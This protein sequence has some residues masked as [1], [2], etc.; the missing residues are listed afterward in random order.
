M[1]NT[2]IFY[3][4]HTA[5]TLRKYLM[6]CLLRLIHKFVFSIPGKI[7]IAQKNKYLGV[8]WKKSLILSWSFEVCCVYLFKLPH[9]GDFND[10]T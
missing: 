3:P 2:K 7:P 4:T 8:F 1:A 5:C 6:I 9:R 10:Y